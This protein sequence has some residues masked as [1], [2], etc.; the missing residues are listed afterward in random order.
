ME[1]K[2][3]PKEPGRR[4]AIV[5]VLISF[6]VLAN[7]AFFLFYT[8]QRL[9]G[10]G[11]NGSSTGENSTNYSVISNESEA[12]SL[13]NFTELDIDVSESI[14][15]LK[16]KQRACQGIVVPIDQ[17]QAYSIQQGIDSKVNFRPLSHDTIRDI[18]ELYEIKVVMMKIIEIRNGIYFGKLVLDNNQKI[19]N[20][21]VRP[22]DGISVAV[23]VGAPIYISKSLFEE[24]KEDI[25]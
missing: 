7:F 9:N 25:C 13:D 23:R 5:L 19:V 20:L 24:L 14:I 22:S 1:N 8:A 2:K 4:I 18:L 3:Q 10:T 17:Y 12:L 21:D 6:L 15:I 16:D 11:G